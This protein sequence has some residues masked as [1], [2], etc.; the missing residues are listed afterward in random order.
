MSKDPSREQSR[1]E[2]LARLGELLA[3]LAHEVRNPL[4]TIGLNLQLIREDLTDS[5][6]P[7]D[8]RTHKRLTVVEAEVRRLQDI[9]EEFLRFARMP[10]LHTGSVDLNALLQSVVDFSEPELRDRGISLRFYPGVDVG[11]A[12]LDAGQVRAA[13]INLVRNAADACDSGDEVIVSSRRDGDTVFV[14]V[15]DSGSGMTPEVMAKV[16]QPYFSTKKAGTGLGLPMVRRTVELHGGRV[17]VSSEVGRGTQF[18][19]AFP[20]THA[21]GGNDDG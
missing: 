3:G 15:I 4:S 2:Q 6:D 18:T 12:D 13:L 5:D 14:Q 17:D 19:L 16:F 8:R 1:T 11:S 21:K 10:E 7:R 20:V 9:L